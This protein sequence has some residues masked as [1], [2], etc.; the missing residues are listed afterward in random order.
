[1]SF[2]IIP[3]HEHAHRRPVSSSSYL[4]GRCGPAAKVHP[5][6]HSDLLGGSNAIPRP[7]FGA[8]LGGDVDFGDGQDQVLTGL[9]PWEHQIQQQMRRQEYLEDVQRRRR[10]AQLE[11]E[12]QRERERAR[13]ERAARAAWQQQQEQQQRIAAAIEFQRRVEA[14]QQRQQQQQQEYA[15]RVRQAALRRKESAAQAQQKWEE[16]AT[17]TLFGIFS[18]AEQFFGG[19]DEEQVASPSSTELRSES[20]KPEEVQPVSAEQQADQQVD[21]MQVDKEIVEHEQQQEVETEQQ[22]NSTQP[23]ALATSQER[24]QVEANAD[25]LIFTYPLPQDEAARSS[26][27]ANNIDVSFDESRRT[28]QLSGL[29]PEELTNDTNTS[30]TTVQS[31]QG[32]DAETRGRKR[33]RSPKRSRVSDV[34]EKTGEEI[35]TP[36]EDEEFVQVD[37]PE[38]QN[39]VTKTIRLPEDASAVGLRAEITDEG[40][41]VYVR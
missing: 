2:I 37:K 38:K 14:I 24:P 18:L 8:L 26:I 7:L 13:R 17:Q 31:E 15:E 40:F 20:K 39:S 21:Q 41:R 35:H 3:S 22:A 25:R 33:S 5:S 27:Q 28:I 1:M 32:G 34:D 29:W 12:R 9:G 36:D 16:A 4:G 23:A 19:Q 6:L 10:Y 30:S 11:Q